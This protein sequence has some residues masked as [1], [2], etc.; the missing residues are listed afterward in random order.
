MKKFGIAIIGTG[1]ISYNHLE[2][3]LAERDRCNIVALCNLHTEKCEKLAKAYDIDVKDLIITDDYRTLLDRDDI[4]VVSICLP[5]SAHCKIACDFLDHGKNVL[6]EKPMASSLEEADMM[7]SSQKKSG[8]ILGM[9][10]QYRFKDSI[11]KVKKMMESGAFGKLYMTQVNSMWFRGLMYYDLWWRGTWE[12]EGGGC[13]LNHC[14]HQ[15]DMLNWFV[16]LP[17]RVTSVF[18]NVAHGNSEVEDCGMSIL[19]YPDSLAQIN[20]SLNNM[21]P[22]QELIFQCERA[23]VSIPWSVHCKKSRSD[24]FSEPDEESERKFQKMYD[25]TE[26][27]DG[28]EGFRAEIKNYLDALQGKDELVVTGENG[29][30]TLQLIYSIYKSATLRETVRLPL[31]KDDAFYKKESFLEEVPHFNEK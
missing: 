14:V 5:P 20:V 26:G 22:K 3:Y 8:K 4:D 29:R 24:G 31:G 18:A 11:W 16:G 6:V 30:D 21:D 15:I 25:E 12:K 17:D 9:V 10:S 7:I 2:G 23:T 27:L 28:N 13:T 1:D 19:E